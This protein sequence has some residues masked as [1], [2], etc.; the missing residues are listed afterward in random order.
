MPEM[1]KRPD[2]LSDLEL[3]TEALYPVR[4][5]NYIF[6]NV[7]SASFARKMPLDFAALLTRQVK[8]SFPSHW[9]VFNGLTNNELFEIDPDINHINATGKLSGSLSWLQTIKQADL[10]ITPD[11]AAYHMA[12]G[13]GVK[14]LVFFTNVKP[15]SR[16]GTY[17]HAVGLDLD[18]DTNF[19]DRM[20]IENPDR[21]RGIESVWRSLSPETLKSVLD[22]LQRSGAN[23]A[24]P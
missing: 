3:P 23:P 19:S 15:L 11:S 12:E 16:L 1:R 18:P 13:L 2:W 10:V 4:G 5:Q 22:Q 14:S 7:A 8:Q 20:E 9:L 21:L 24:Y 6:I 17:M